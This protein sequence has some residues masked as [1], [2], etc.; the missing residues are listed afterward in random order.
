[1]SAGACCHCK[2][3]EEAPSARALFCSKTFQ[4]FVSVSRFRL[5]PGHVFLKC[6]PQVCA[7]SGVEGSFLDPDPVCYHSFVQL[8]FVE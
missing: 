1:M 7:G 2:C 5:L 6:I 8:E 4:R 3:T